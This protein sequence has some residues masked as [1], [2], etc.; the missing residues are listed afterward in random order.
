MMEGEL[1][2]RCKRLKVNDVEIDVFDTAVLGGEEE[3]N[4]VSSLLVGHLVTEKNF[5]VEVFKCTM[6]Q[7]WGLTNAL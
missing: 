1:I 5:N 6:T 7:V 3:T 4:Q 2:K